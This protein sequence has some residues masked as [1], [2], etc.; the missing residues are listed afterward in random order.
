M[1]RP[2]LE[3]RREVNA[4]VRRLERPP[5]GRGPL[6]R[7]GAGE[8]REEDPGESASAHAGKAIRALI[9][10]RADP[11]PRTDRSL[12]KETKDARRRTPRTRRRSLRS[13]LRS[14]DGRRTLGAR[15][16]AHRRDP[17]ARDRS[18]RARDAVRRHV[19]RRPLPHDGRRRDVDAPR[20]RSARRRRRSRRRRSVRAKGRLGRDASGRDL[21]QRRW[22]RFVEARPRRRG[23]GVDGDRDRPE[24]RGVRR[25][26]HG[27]RAA[28]HPP[29]PRRRQDL[30]ALG[31][32]IP[33]QLPH[34]FPG[35]RSEDADDPLRGPPGRGRLQVHRLGRDVGAVERRHRRRVRAVRSRSIRPIRSPSGSEPTGSSSAATT[36]E[37]RG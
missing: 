23:P 21:P 14:A 32:R 9:N 11:D 18:L 1:A 2:G 28:R 16:T 34:P 17:D 33:P 3:R 35:G 29:L 22:R 4:K 19:S 7:G 31:E 12:A 27:R 30:D 36:P 20:R 24:G 5:V 8:N 6:R 26:R 15:R 10:C 25:G 13:L 37:R